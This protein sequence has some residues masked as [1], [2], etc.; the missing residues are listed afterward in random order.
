MLKFSPLSF[1]ITNV[2]SQFTVLHGKDTA[3]GLSFLHASQYRYYSEQ[4]ILDNIM[5]LYEDS[6]F[7]DVK[8]IYSIVSYKT[9]QALTKHF[10]ANKFIHKLIVYSDKIDKEDN[11]IDYVKCDPIAENKKRDF[12]KFH[13]EKLQLNLDT[14]QDYRWVNNLDDM[15]F[16][17]ILQRLQIKYYER[18]RIVTEDDPW[19][20][21]RHLQFTSD[22]DEKYVYKHF[23]LWAR[24]NAPD[25][26][27]LWFYLKRIQETMQQRRNKL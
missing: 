9:V 10:I 25:T 21:M 24:D 17:T 12:I 19:Y 4:N 11:A 6:L 3:L 27:C 23:E 16:A 7:D 20:T 13:N 5:L 14:T 26:T 8:N 15:K 18:E 1:D 22:K 2:K